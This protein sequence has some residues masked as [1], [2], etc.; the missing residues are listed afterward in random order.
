ML[1]VWATTQDLVQ[2]SWVVDGRHHRI[3]N[4]D[5]R[6][7]KVHKLS[8]QGSVEVILALGRALLKL[9][10]LATEV[11]FRIHT[12]VIPPSLEHGTDYDHDECCIII[13]INL[14]LFMP[15][16]R[17]N[18]QEVKN[19]GYLVPNWQLIEGHV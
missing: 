7:R 4:Y 16:D 15:H 19:T 5:G 10:S 17:I 9:R 8:S 2:R 18:E 13:S 6:Y 14:D 12:L 3:Y 1:A 11:S